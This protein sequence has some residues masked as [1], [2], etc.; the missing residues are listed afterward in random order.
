LSIGGGQA[1]LVTLEVGADS[2]PD[3]IVH[4]GQEFV[5]CLKGHLAYTIDGQPYLLEPGDSLIFEA[6]LPHRWGQSG[7]VATRAMLILCPTDQNDRP[8]DRHF[9]TSFERR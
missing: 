2:G 6:H 4:T 1:L 7:D 5:Y 8:T 9:A 3:P